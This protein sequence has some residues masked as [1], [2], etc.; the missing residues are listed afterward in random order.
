MADLSAGRVCAYPFQKADEANSLA[1][2]PARGER[3]SGGCASDRG[4]KV[5]PS[6]E[7]PESE[8]DSLAHLMRV[9]ARHSK[10]DRLMSALGY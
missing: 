9:V 1:L 6:H 4:N 2:L 5:A 3:P 10:S 8:N 7:S